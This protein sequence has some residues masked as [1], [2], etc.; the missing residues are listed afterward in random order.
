VLEK[1]QAAI[2]ELNDLGFNYRLVEGGRQRSGESRKGT[3]QIDP[4]KPCSVCGFQ[5]IPPHDARRHRGQ[6]NKKP[7]TSK[8]LEEQGLTKA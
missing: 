7:F 5:T 8:E 6:T 2:T 1:V 4:S 3:R